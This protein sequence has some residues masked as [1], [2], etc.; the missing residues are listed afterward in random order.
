MM[1]IIFNMVM[2]EAELSEKDKKDLQ[3]VVD[4]DV[5]WF[6]QLCLFEIKDKGY[7]DFGLFVKCYCYVYMLKV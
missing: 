6:N 4:Y 3:F 7:F 1:W 2:R 5:S